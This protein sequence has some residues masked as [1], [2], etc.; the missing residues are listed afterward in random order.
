[1][2]AGAAATFGLLFVASLGCDKFPHNPQPE[3]R[4]VPRGAAPVLATG[5]PLGALDHQILR[6]INPADADTHLRIWMEFERAPGMTMIHLSRD[7][8]TNLDTFVAPFT[9]DG[10]PPLEVDNVFCSRL[11]DGSRVPIPP[12][13]LPFPM[14]EKCLAYPW[15]E[16]NK[17]GNP[18]ATITSKIKLERAMATVT[19]FRL[20]PVEAWSG[21]QIVHLINVMKLD[22]TVRNVQLSVEEKIYDAA[23][24]QWYPPPNVSGSHGIS[25]D[26]IRIECELRPSG[27]RV[28]NGCGEV[29]VTCQPIT[30]WWGARVWITGLSGLLMGH[31]LSDFQGALTDELVAKLRAGVWLHFEGY[32]ADGMTINPTASPLPFLLL[33][34]GTPKDNCSHVP[35]PP[36]SAPAPVRGIARVRP[37][38]GLGEQ[39]IGDY[40][41]PYNLRP[42]VKIDWA[43]TIP[44]VA[45]TPFLPWTLPD[46]Y[47]VYG[48]ELSKLT[49]LGGYIKHGLEQLRIQTSIELVRAEIR[50]ACWR[51]TTMM[52]DVIGPIQTGGGECPSCLTEQAFLSVSYGGDDM[53][54]TRKVDALMGTRNVTLMNKSEVAFNDVYRILQRQLGDQVC[55]GTNCPDNCPGNVC[56]DWTRYDL[57]P[58]GPFDP[59]GRIPPVHF[60]LWVS[61]ELPLPPSFHGFDPQFCLRPPDGERSDRRLVPPKVT[62]PRLQIDS[63]EFQSDLI[64]TPFADTPAVTFPTGIDGNSEKI[65]GGGRAAVRASKSDAEGTRSIEITLTDDC[66]DHRA[67]THL[68]TP[69][70]TAQFIPPRPGVVTVTRAF[71]ELTPTRYAL[72]DTVFGPSA[73]EYNSDLLGLQLLAVTGTLDRS[74]LRFYTSVPQIYRDIGLT[75]ATRDYR[76]STIDAN[77]QNPWTTPMLFD[78]QHGGAFPSPS[79]DHLGAFRHERWTSVDHRGHRF[80]YFADWNTDTFTSEWV[81]DE[82]PS[83]C[84]ADDMRFVSPRRISFKGGGLMNERELDA[85]DV[86]TY[87]PLG[88]DGRRAV[89]SHST[90]G[91]NFWRVLH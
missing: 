43:S 86:M 25:I 14:E 24:T 90:T 58:S 66:P 13:P 36:P 81:G 51:Q 60:E 89:F 5:V 2:R 50:G 35:P 33:I 41:L 4:R 45:S 65:L 30:E 63:A 1:M 76:E 68:S 72:G 17:P 79:L 61:H 57:L 69:C 47:R 6:H 9:R 48:N 23:G 84:V 29:L 16:C 77:A 15:G 70:W 27:T 44:N 80:S 56:E 55:P 59:G 40:V 82:P 85:S 34:T 46:G 42:E 38:Y 53:L 74:G 75:T 88:P 19:N 26:S 21:G 31:N 10:M 39:V 64:E 54:F 67:G 37:Q 49:P 8:T 52:K 71:S 91:G 28:S 20:T 32:S 11:P 22:L 78:W 18:P 73:S 7:V 62:L 3:F 87:G 83:F 12:L